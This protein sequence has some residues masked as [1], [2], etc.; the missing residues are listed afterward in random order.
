MDLTPLKRRIW[1]TIDGHV[2]SPAGR[3]FVVGI[4]AL[5]VLNVIAVILETEDVVYRGRETEFEVFDWISVSIFA[6]E[7]VLR[8]FA[9]TVDPRYAGPIRGR[10]KFM[11]QPLS[12]VDLAAILPAFLPM[13]PIDLR[14]LR[15]FRLARFLRVLKL[16]RYSESFQT[17]HNVLRAKRS[18]LWVAISAALLLLLLAS[19]LMYF[20]EHDVQPKVFSSIPASMWWAVVT[21]TTVGYGD[22]YPVTVAGKLIASVIALSSVGLFALPAGILA[23]G[24]NDEMQRKRRKVQICPKC[25]ETMPVV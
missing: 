5:I 2:V 20:C 23:S 9:C 13:L 6:V 18:E 11:L 4:S 12:L 10:L 1:R 19:G 8:V 14:L 21:L 3:T 24:F 15:L 16:G 25:G 17:L 7:Y 22:V